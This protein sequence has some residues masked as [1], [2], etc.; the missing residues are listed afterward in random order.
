MQSPPLQLMPVSTTHYY[1]SG[2]VTVHPGAAIAPGVLLQADPGSRIVIHQSVC[3]GLGSVIQAH[4]GTIE[5][6][7]GVIIGAGVLL[8]GELTVGDRACVGTGTT[9]M[10]RSI[11]S[12]SIVPPGS[13]LC[14]ELRSAAVEEPTEEVYEPGFCPPPPENKQ[15]EA[16]KEPELVKDVWQNNG[17]K[18]QIEE[19]SQ[20]NGAK[21]QTTAAE[22]NGA[23]PTV[24]AQ[25]SDEIESPASQNGQVYGQAY[26]NR[27][28]GKMFPGQR[29]ANDNGN[30]S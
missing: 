5:L 7:E 2:N 12:L 24:E 19:I 23:K 22:V 10:N 27:L 30:P 18:P 14:E 20:T 3:V 17:S 13:L 9:V 25:E 16:V 28:L 26:V 1:V 15:P 8:I 6:G 21:P 4:E 11:A 29:S